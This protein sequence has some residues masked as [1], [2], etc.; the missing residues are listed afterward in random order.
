MLTALDK[1]TGAI[2]VLPDLPDPNAVRTPTNEG[3]LVCSTCRAALWLRVGPVR[4]PH[5]AHRV[6]AECPAAHASADVIRARLLLYNFFK[7]RIHSGKLLATVD[8]EPV[9]PGAPKGFRVDLLL[10][11]DGKPTVAV[12]LLE[13]RLSPELRVEFESRLKAPDFAFRPV[14]LSGLLRPVDGADAE[15]NLDTTQRALRIPSAYDLRSDFVADV[16]GTLHFIDPSEGTWVSLRGLQLRHSPQEF[17]ASKVLR[18]PVSALLWSELHSEWCHPGEAEALRNWKAREQGRSR[19]IGGRVQSVAAPG[20][21]PS[22]AGSVEEAPYEP[23]A[24][25]KD[26]LRCVCCGKVS[27]DWQQAQPGAGICVCR[28]C[29]SN[30]ERLSEFSR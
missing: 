3:Q 2:I 8:L 7:Q 12:V 27:L 10:H 18:S 29:F 1:T 21:R 28:G 6:L 24:W 14:F 13:K 11:R 17:R 15:F 22:T 23:P 25:L 16:P 26:G 4:V 20:S 5:F 9:T 19:P 30:G